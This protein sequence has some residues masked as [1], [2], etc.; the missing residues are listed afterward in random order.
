MK[1]RGNSVR[2][3]G[4]GRWPPEGVARPSIAGGTWPA[5]PPENPCV[6]PGAN[7]FLPKREVPPERRF[8]ARWG[9]AR[10]CGASGASRGVASAASF[11]AGIARIIGDALAS[12]GERHGVEPEA[13]SRFNSPRN[14]S[15]SVWSG[16]TCKSPAQRKSGHQPRRGAKPAGALGA[17]HCSRPLRAPASGRKAI[18]AGRKDW[19]ADS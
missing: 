13:A 4:D 10:A 14:S 16:P 6:H 11:A 3:P 19:A 17:A 9:K 5:K 18:P 7:P 2:D 15:K 12:A 8:P 1:G